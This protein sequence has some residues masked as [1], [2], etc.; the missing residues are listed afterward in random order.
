MTNERRNRYV[1]HIFHNEFLPHLGMERGSRATYLK[2][3]M[4][5][6]FVVRRLLRRV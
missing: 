3:G 1:E 6:G 2:K 5:L 4:Y